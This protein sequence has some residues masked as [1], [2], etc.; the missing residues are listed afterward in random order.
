MKKLFVML[1]MLFVIGGFAADLPA[2][3]K[4]WGQN[5]RWDNY[6][7]VIAKVDDGTVVATAPID[8]AVYQICKKMTGATTGQ[9]LFDFAQSKKAEWKSAKAVG[10]YFSC[11]RFAVR[12]ETN[13]EFLNTVTNFCKAAYNVPDEKEFARQSLLWIYGDSQKCGEAFLYLDNGDAPMTIYNIIELGVRQKT[14][15]PVAAYNRIVDYFYA[16]PPKMTGVW[17]GKLFDF[18]MRMAVAAQ[19]PR[20]D[21]KTVVS[22][23]DQLYASVGT[24][25]TDWNQFRDKL[26]SQLESFKRNQ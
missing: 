16:F 3:G 19:I 2:A 7:E 21:L 6:A 18:G 1:T 14:I 11:L 20:T 25:D 26:K 13:E 10:A 4:V 5:G 24:S 9:Q 17:A 8:V 15:T 22:N 23:L 12:N